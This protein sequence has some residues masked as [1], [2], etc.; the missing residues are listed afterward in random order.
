M[1]MAIADVLA[2][3]IPGFPA[4][5]S[6]WTRPTSPAIPRMPRSRRAP[7][8]AC[9]IASSGSEPCICASAT[10]AARP[11]RRANGG[12]LVGF[13]QRLHVDHVMLEMAHRP[14]DDL[15]AFTAVDPSSG[16]ASA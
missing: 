10:M 15:D 6:K 9:W 3:Q 8:T 14:P 13:P 1:I 2:A 12:A 11:S 5:A 16:W 4:I 7:S